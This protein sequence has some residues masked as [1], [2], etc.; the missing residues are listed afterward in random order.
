MKTLI[1]GIVLFFVPHSIA[2][3]S[4]GWRDK[5]ALTLGEWGWK[6]VYS[7]VSL[8]G[9]VL[10]IRG[11]SEAHMASGVV[12]ATPAWLKHLAMLLMLPVFP[13]LLSTYLPGRIKSA[14]KHPTLVATILWSIAHLLVNGSVA[15]LWLFGSFLLWAMA[16]LFSMSH[17]PSRALLT[18]PAG[19]ANDLVAVIVG[20]GVYAAVVFVLHTVIAGVP[21]VV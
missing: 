6:A 19:K 16:C 1:L 8:I 2:I 3:V 11:Y 10:I 17:R 14:I 13:L 21:L 15:D 7:V 9:F 20:L 12:Y 5:A 4:H 18:A